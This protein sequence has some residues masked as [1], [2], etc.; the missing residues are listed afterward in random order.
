MILDIKKADTT[1]V[2]EISKVINETWR[3][4]YKGWISAEDLQH[5]TDMSYRERSTLEGMS[6]WREYYVMSCDKEIVAICGVEQSRERDLRDGYCTILQLYVL[7]E[8]Q[9][10]GLGKKLLSHTLREMRKKGY[11]NAL[12]W[13]QVI[14]A[15][16]RR[17]YEKIGFVSGI[18][19]K[20]TMFKKPLDIVRYTIE[21]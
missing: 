18:T 11:K 1:R 3:D 5:Y 13:T 9:K 15:P 20:G 7:P 14:N 19:E 12:L 10:I 6:N 17:F 8:Y 4:C 21:L 2:C 16:A